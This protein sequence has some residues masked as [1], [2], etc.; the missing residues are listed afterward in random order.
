MNKRDIF[1]I[2]YS[3]YFSNTLSYSLEN[4][5]ITAINITND[6]LISRWC[7]VEWGNSLI[8]FEKRRSK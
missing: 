6:I 5:I 3:L 2:N 8:M 4:L 7:L 1:M